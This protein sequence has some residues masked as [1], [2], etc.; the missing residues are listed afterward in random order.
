MTETNSELIRLS[1][2]ALAEK[3]AAREVPAV[4]VTQAPP[5]G[6]D[7]RL[8]LMVRDAADRPVLL[9]TYLG[10][11]AHVTG[12]HRDSGAMVHLHPMSEPEVTEDG[13]GLVFHSEIEEPGDYLLFV[14]VRVDGYL[15]T[16]PTAM[17][18]T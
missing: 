5:V 17:A 13:S 10:T 2:A 15:H 7:E 6:R 9:D 4:E 14:Q 1:A 16:V 18:V 12:F 8:G 3:L 11:Y